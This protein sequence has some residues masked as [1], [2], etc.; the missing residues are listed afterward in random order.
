MVGVAR[1]E[2]KAMVG[3]SHSGWPGDRPVRPRVSVAQLL[4]AKNSR[5][6]QSLDEMAAD[7]FESDRELED[8]LAF[9]NAD[10]RL[11]LA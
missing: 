10:R 1:A 5:P 3:F 4:A 11:G 6:L 9:I 2:V 8:F 7:T